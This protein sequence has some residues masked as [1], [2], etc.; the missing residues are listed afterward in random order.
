MG[1]T[2][3]IV[4]L[5]SS[6]ISAMSS[7][8]TGSQPQPTPF[9]GPTVE[10]VLVVKDIL[11]DVSPLP[12]EIID[13]IIDHAEYWPHTTSSFAHTQINVVGSSIGHENKLVAR[14][15]PLGYLPSLP[16]SSTKSTS[17][18]HNYNIEPQDYYTSLINQTFH[19]PS[20]DILPN[21]KA[22]TPTVLSAWK[23][24]SSPRE[25]HPCRKIVF[26]LK[27]HDQGWGGDLGQ[28]GT[29]TGSYTWFDVGRERIRAVDVEALLPRLDESGQMM[30]TNLHL[31]PYLMHH[32][33]R[34]PEGALTGW[35]SLRFDIE[36]LDPSFEASKGNRYGERLE[37]PFLPHERTL[38]KNLTA[39]R[40][41][42]ERRIEWRWDDDVRP[43]SGEADELEEMGRGKETGG[44]DFVRSLEVGD[45]VSVWAR[46]RF[47]GWVHTVEDV[48]I[49]VYWAV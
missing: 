36:T 23:S 33:D 44:G 28:K 49:E 37:H 35:G 18:T 6:I 34:R 30:D 14:S 22:N 20:V 42:Q 27:S 5:G 4:G 13:A 2:S 38:Q 15:L 45:I 16:P 32:N 24:R 48:K 17:N 39:T 11:T 29:F 47:Q 31:R 12:L 3:F 43:G 26:H 9:T 40:E 25:A 21:M 8:R 46:A 41:M 7:P 10:D 19:R 1:V